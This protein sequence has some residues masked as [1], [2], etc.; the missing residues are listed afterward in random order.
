L[1]GTKPDRE[2]QRSHRGKIDESELKKFENTLYMVA[3]AENIARLLAGAQAPAWLTDVI[4]TLVHMVIQRHWVDAEL[5]TREDLHDQ[6]CNLRQAA[7]LIAAELYSPSIRDFVRWAPFHASF[8]DNDLKEALQAMR[9]RIDVALRSKA[10]VVVPGRVNKGPGPA[11]A[12]MRLPPQIFV[13][14]VVGEMWRH[15]PLGPLAPHGRK[16]AEIAVKLWVLAGGAPHR[17]GDEPLAVWGPRFAK[18]LNRSSD[19]HV[20]EVLEIV[21]GNM[22]ECLATEGR[23]LRLSGREKKDVIV[24]D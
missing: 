5:L 10:L 15:F 24:G 23:S 4:L 20:E 1:V 18:V 2:Q 13:T 3:E 22:R 9:D 7:A 17:S 6:L 12:P 16:I 21:R 11:R 14:V 8:S 19:L